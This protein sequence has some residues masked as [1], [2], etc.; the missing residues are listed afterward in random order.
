MLKKVKRVIIGK[1]LKNKQLAEEKFDVLWGLP[2][3][4]SDAISSVAYAG[5][6]ILLVLIPVVGMLAFRQLSFYSAAIILLLVILTLSYR[7]TIE[8]YPNGGGAYMVAKENMG[9]HAGIVAGAALS[10]SYVLTVAVSISSAIEQL[11][12]AFKTLAPYRI[13]LCVVMILLMTLINLRGIKESSKIF[14]LPTYAFILFIL[15]LIV[16]GLIKVFQGSIPPP[17]NLPHEPGHPL[18]LFL[19][20]SAFTNGCAALTG[21][22]AVSNSVPNFKEPATQYAQRVLVLLSTLV[23]IV[24]GGT[25]LMAYFFPVDP[26]QG[27]M[28]IQMTELIFGRNLAFYIMTGL[29]FAILVLAA[30]TAYVGFPNLI[31]VMAQEGYAP[32]QLSMRG[33]RLSFSNGIISLSVLAILLIMLFNAHVTKLIGLYAIGV[34]ISFTLSQ[35]GM[36]IQWLRNK[37]DGWKRKAFL[38]GLGA[39]TTASVVL[40][41]AFTKFFQG[42]WMVVVIVPAMALVMFKIKTHYTAVAKQLVIR[43]KDFENLDL[44]A[45]IY[46]NRV[47]VPISGINKSSI[48]ALRYAKTISNQVAAFCV[49]TN[50]D[51]SSKVRSD[52]ERI[53]LGIPLVIRHSHYRKVVDPLLRYIA[54]VEY[55]YQKGDMITVILPQFSVKK[56]WHRFLHNNTLYFVKKE[57]LKHKHIV[58]AV[59][60]LQLKED[61]WVM[62]HP[63]YD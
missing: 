22:E 4:A 7:Q 45:G 21:V 49:A 26:S 36:F 17:L 11:S 33:D 12:S 44:T 32:R 5:Q 56:W 27:A 2:I 19:V 1:P 30:N 47:I 34:F 61:H 16:V 43:E 59:M 57:L 52:F 51:Q 10:V 58:V 29:T 35:S 48:R 3:L 42:A 25:S 37:E 14:S 60:P 31:S 9:I 28:L 38:N 63:K 39:F 6:E 23:L 24:F 41:V 46:R 54:S 15:L 40:M 53:A 13:E 62:H 20:L 18:T 8:K 55:G 50:E